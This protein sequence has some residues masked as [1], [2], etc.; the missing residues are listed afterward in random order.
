E[1]RQ[2]GR[3]EEVEAGLHGPILAPTI[4]AGLLGSGIDDEVT[5]APLEERLGGEGAPREHR[6]EIR[7][8]VVEDRTVVQR[9]VAE[10]PD[11]SLEPVPAWEARDRD[12]RAQLAHPADDRLRFVGVIEDA[13]RE[14]DVKRSLDPGAQEIPVDELDLRPVPTQP[15]GGKLEHR[16]RE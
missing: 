9:L 16:A 12:A 14:H 3:D 15:A 7:L 8:G 10:L 1:Q 2:Q 5:P 13:E 4:R 6:T 11:R